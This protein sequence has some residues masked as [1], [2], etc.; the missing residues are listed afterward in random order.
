[1]S[2]DGPAAPPPF[3][4]PEDLGFRYVTDAS[5]LRDTVDA[6]NSTRVLAVDTESD[7]FYSYEESC[8][9]VQ[10]TGDTGPD[11]V[12]DPLRVKDLSPLAGLMADP[13]VTKIFHGADYD[14]VSLKR[15]FGFT[16]RGIFDTMIAAQAGGHQRFGL[17]DLVHRYFGVKLNKKYQRHDWSSRPLKPEHL[18]YARLDSHFLPKLMGILRPLA[19][20]RGRGAM[21]AEEFTLLEAREWSRRPF[22]GDDCMKIKGATK[23]DADQR[24]VLRAVFLARDE[25]ARRRNRPAFK[26]WGNDSCLLLAEKQPTTKVELAKALGATH[27]VVRRY[28]SDVCVAVADGLAD[29]SAAPRT[30]K[31]AEAPRD[32]R[33]PPFTR[34]D[35]PL[36]AALKKWRNK[37]STDEAMAPGLIVNNAVMRS[38]AALK[39]ESVA[40]L[41]LIEEMR[42]WQRDRYGQA[43]VERVAEWVQA[44]AEK[45]KKRAEGG[46]KKRRRRRRRRRQSSG[47]GDGAGARQNSPTS[48]SP[49]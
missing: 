37:Q 1:M 18:A 17:G 26:V 14:V 30:P 41:E 28:A 10:I 27:H 39:P 22:S 29:E 38:A 46:G 24:K 5:G 23:L 13:G 45:A 34:D 31:P 2:E 32:P 42:D 12:I 33:L 36:M 19:E 6:L 11:Y 40:D 47:G 25:Q 4:P 3:D 9:L 15:D 48:A 16:I 43:I 44:E 20:E 8:C 21:L 7:S 35:E 49:E